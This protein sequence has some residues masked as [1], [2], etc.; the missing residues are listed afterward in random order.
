MPHQQ[1]RVAGPASAQGVPASAAGRVLVALRRM[2]HALDLHSHDLVEEFGITS[3]QL[4]CL[5][6]LV[7]SASLT[8]SQLARRVYL[9]P[10]TVVGILDRLET[11][12]WITRQR[13]GTD[14]RKVQVAATKDGTLLVERAPSPLQ[15]RLAAALALLSEHDQEETALSLEHVVD[16]MDAAHVEPAPI[17]E[18][19]H[20][21]G[22]SRG[23]PE[24]SQPSRRDAAGEP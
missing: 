24:E 16:L 12:G 18:S 6:A 23:D 9:S 19:R 4:F 1:E 13:D 20:A 11:K 15:A 17:L 8:V 7:E 2:V 10:A 5:R 14:R 21:G 3:P 22:P